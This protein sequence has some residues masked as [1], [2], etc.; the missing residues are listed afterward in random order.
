MNS[1]KPPIP[2]SEIVSRLNKS[3]TGKKTVLG[4]VSGYPLYLVRVKPS[5]PIARV[6]ISAGIH[7]DEPSGVLALLSLI[8]SYPSWL[9][10]FE[11]FL[12][13][14]L[15]PWGYENSVRTNELS[16]DINRQ[17]KSETS[18]EV[19]FVKKVLQNQRFDLLICLHED[20]DGT[21]FYLY[22][23]SRGRR[24]C[25]TPIIQKTSKVIPIDPRARI[26]GRTP[27]NGV[28]SR[29]FES[30]QRRKYWPEA[31][32]HIIHHSEHTLT[33]ETPSGFPLKKRIRTQI[34]AIQ[35]AL[36]HSL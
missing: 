32:Y 22:E 28:I 17:W 25:G 9:H 31:L 20:Y 5:K 1:L 24:T 6:V 8:E 15:N 16:L 18:A 13:P 36:Q 29:S 23:L 14:C 26:E 30:I 19:L 11:L 35:T 27:R 3:K 7:G 34:I 2:Y 10:Q 12:F 33:T 4:R 21:G